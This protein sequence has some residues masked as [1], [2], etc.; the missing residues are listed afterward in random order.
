MSLFLAVKGNNRRGGLPW[1][2]SDL[3]KKKSHLLMQE[4]RV[5]SLGW[6][7]SLE[8]ELAIHSSILAW[9]ILLTK[10]AVG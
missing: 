6:E 7:G 5:Q 8:K 10:D 3:K 1:W 9:E 2:L 4:T